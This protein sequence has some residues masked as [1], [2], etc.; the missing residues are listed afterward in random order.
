MGMSMVDSGRESIRMPD[1]V[2][3]CEKLTI[4]SKVKMSR[5]AGFIVQLS[6]I[7]LSP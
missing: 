6:N 2:V 3:S 7:I 1:E 4:E 5:I